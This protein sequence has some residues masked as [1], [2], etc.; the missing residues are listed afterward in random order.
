MGELKKEK[1]KEYYDAIYES[2]ERYALPALGIMFYNTLWLKSVLL[3]LE[4][5]PDSIVELGCGPGHFASLLARY[6]PADFKQYTGIDF[7]DVSVAQCGEKVS[8]SRFSFITEDLSSY[9]FTSHFKGSSLVVSHEFFEH[10]YFELD[11][12]AKMPSGTPIL[13]SVPSYDDPAHMKY[14]TSAESVASFYRDQ[15]SFNAIYHIPV[16]DQ[17]IFLAHAVVK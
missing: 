11:L 9:D 15:L 3:A 6:L 16:G 10:I 5:K 12:F 7:S 14:F 17:F 2:S 13:F 8:D 4:L 1:P